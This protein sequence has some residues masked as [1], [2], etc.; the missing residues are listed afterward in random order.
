M[1]V[2][3]VVGQPKTTTC[4]IYSPITIIIIIIPKIGT[5]ILE[6]Y[7]G[8]IIKTQKLYEVE[9]IIMPILYV[10]KLRPKNHLVI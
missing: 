7:M 10:K 5:V 4:N 2:N 1:L 6:P 8:Y 9:I 3:C